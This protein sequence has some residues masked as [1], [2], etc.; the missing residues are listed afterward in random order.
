MFLQGMRSN[1]VTQTRTTPQKNQGALFYKTN[2]FKILLEED[3]GNG[4]LRIHSHPVW[5]LRQAQFCLFGFL[6][7]PGDSRTP[8]WAEGSVSLSHS[9]CSSRSH[10]LLPFPAQL[11]VQPP[12]RAQPGSSAE[13]SVSWFPKALRKIK[14]EWLSM[15]LTFPSSSPQKRANHHFW[16]NR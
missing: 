4:N 13:A 8:C 7:I 2:V 1:P 9:R 6:T 11:A 15:H 14:L 3:G 12:G 5:N 10:S 16:L